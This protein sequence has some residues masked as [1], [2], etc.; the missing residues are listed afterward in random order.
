M[1]SLSAQDDGIIDAIKVKHPDQPVLENET[2]FSSSAPFVNNND[3]VA[4]TLKNAIGKVSEN[5]RTTM[6]NAKDKIMDVLAVDDKSVDE[7]ETIHF[8]E[9]DMMD[10]KRH[11]SLIDNSGIMKAAPQMEY[12]TTFI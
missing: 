10:L 7:T 5:L 9:N 1:S 8:Q 3:S 12:F 11:V 4:S 6:Q 2:I